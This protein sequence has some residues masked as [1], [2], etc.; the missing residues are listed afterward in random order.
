M[1]K[2]T[3]PKSTPKKKTTPKKATRSKVRSMGGAKGKIT[4]KTAHGKDTNPGEKDGRM[5]AARQA[6]L[7]KDVKKAG[8]AKKYLSAAKKSE[9]R[10]VRVGST[11]TTKG[12]PRH[13]AALKKASRK[14]MK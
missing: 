4:A 1:S 11:Y 2:K 13:K 3:T 7:D 5:A 6:S 12:S 9:S 14:K 8:G 10:Q